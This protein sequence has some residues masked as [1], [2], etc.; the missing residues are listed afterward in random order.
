MHDFMP[1]RNSDLDSPKFHPNEG[2]YLSAVS[3]TIKKINIEIIQ[4]TS[5]VL[6]NRSKDKS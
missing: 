5:E 4:D 6:H 1:R 3:Q 2:I